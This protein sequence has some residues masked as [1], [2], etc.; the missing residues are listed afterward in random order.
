[1]AAPI[2]A[3]WSRQKGDVAGVTTGGR[4]ET[5]VASCVS[6]FWDT[7]LGFSFAMLTAAPIPEWP[8]IWISRDWRR[9]GLKVDATAYVGPSGTYG[10]GTGAESTN[11]GLPEALPPAKA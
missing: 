8:G 11:N 4:D 1:M 10:L 9:T 3:L 7:E 2:T 5:A 6:T